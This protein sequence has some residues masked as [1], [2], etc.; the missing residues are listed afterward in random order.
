MAPQ[1]TLNDTIRYDAVRCIHF[2][3]FFS[4]HV[5]VPVSKHYCM[6][7]NSRHIVIY[8]P[9]SLFVARKKKKKEDI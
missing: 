2:F 5:H 4:F 3:F 6:I 7:M 1:L 9:E 8:F